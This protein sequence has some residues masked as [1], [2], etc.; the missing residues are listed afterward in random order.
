M[1]KSMFSFQVLNAD[2]KMIMHGIA[3]RVLHTDR[4]LFEIVEDGR[5]R[6]SFKMS[7]ASFT[8]YCLED[9][10]HVYYYSHVPCKKTNYE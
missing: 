7:L 9:G 4:Y 10:M 8:E 2:A 6:D 3:S 5:V 1:Y